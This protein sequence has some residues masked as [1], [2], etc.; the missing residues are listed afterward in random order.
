MFLILY[1]TVLY[2]ST[3]YII[4]TS[5]ALFFVFEGRDTRQL[6]LEE[7]TTHLRDVYSELNRKWIL[8][9][10]EGGFLYKRLQSSQELVVL[11][12]AANYY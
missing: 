3:H 7:L 6:Q 11:L 4:T 9:F 5:F 12:C 10:P 8:I 1:N 2:R